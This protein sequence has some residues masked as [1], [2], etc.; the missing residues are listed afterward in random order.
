MKKTY[1]KSRSYQLYAILLA[2]AALLGSCRN[3]TGTSA[4]KTSFDQGRDATDAELADGRNF[5]DSQVIEA[6]EEH[7]NKV[8]LTVRAKVKKILPTDT[9]GLPHERFLLELSNRTTVLVAHDLKMAPSVPIQEG[10]M[11]IIRGEYIWNERGGVI[12][13]THHTDTPRHEGGWIFLNGT[14]YQ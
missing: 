12:H 9:E 1:R 5:D 11:P 14:R 6:Q 13:W 2:T 3:P 10:D 7:L 4:V 8:E